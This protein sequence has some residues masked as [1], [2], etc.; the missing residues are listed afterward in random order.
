MSTTDRQRWDAKYAGQPVPDCLSA[1]PWLREVLAEI[2]PG[3]ALELA[4]GLGHNATWLASGGWQVDAVD[5]S[6]VGL[7]LARQLA[8]NH[9]VDVN[10]ILGDLDSFIPA[11]GT[12]DL[13]VVFRFL[14]R[15]RLPDRIC[16]S[17]TAGGRLVYE[18]FGPGQLDRS[19]NHLKNPEFVL[20]A[21]ELP[22]LFPSLETIVFE[23]CAL[24]DRC[25][26]RLVARQTIE[27]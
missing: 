13:V 11:A 10:W 7:E 25:V 1:D 17:L 5:V 21:G 2:P 23:E 24:E 9:S 8:V 14:D 4:C 6:P 19:D 27:P 15:Q 12:Y 26:A 20:A 22:G 3:R 18:T 16:H